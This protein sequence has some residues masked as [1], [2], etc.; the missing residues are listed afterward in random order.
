[1]T[2]SPGKRDSLIRKTPFAILATLAT[3]MIAGRSFSKKLEPR[4]AGTTTHYPKFMQLDFLPDLERE[5]FSYFQTSCCWFEKTTNCRSPHA[6][7]EII[8]YL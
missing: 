7:R 4:L 8:Q 5:H 3:S 1:M 6:H 2:I